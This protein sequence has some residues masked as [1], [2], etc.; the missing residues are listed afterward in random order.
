[1]F[2]IRHAIVS[3]VPDGAAV[4]A[5]PTVAA[6]GVNQNC[7]VG[8]GRIDAAFLEQHEKSIGTDGCSR[9][10]KHILNRSWIGV[11]VVAGEGEEIISRREDEVGGAWKFD[12]LVR[13]IASWGVEENL[14][15]ENIRGKTRLRGQP[16]K[17]ENQSRHWQAQSVHIYMDSA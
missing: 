4:A 7:R 8:V 2:Q 15:D 9:K 5:P 10:V 3:L 6:A 11:G 16:K 14:I 17:T 12:V 1:M 13:G